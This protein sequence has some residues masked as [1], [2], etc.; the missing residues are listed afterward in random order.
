MPFLYIVD[1]AD[2]GNVD[3]GVKTRDQDSR[4][5]C[6]GVGSSRVRCPVGERKTRTWSW[7][8]SGMARRTWRWKGGGTG[9]TEMDL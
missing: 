1:G 7:V 8:K 3:E 5:M 4:R 6:L 9:G 2:S